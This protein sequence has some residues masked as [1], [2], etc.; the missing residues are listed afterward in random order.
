MSSVLTE[1]GT[2]ALVASASPVAAT[3]APA[4]VDQPRNKKKGVRIR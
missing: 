2:F 4:R 1:T 3:S